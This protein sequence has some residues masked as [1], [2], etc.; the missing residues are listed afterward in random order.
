MELQRAGAHPR[1]LPARVCYTLDTSPANGRTN[2]QKLSATPKLVTILP[3][4]QMHTKTCIFHKQKHLII[5]GLETQNLST[6]SPCICDQPQQ[7]LFCLSRVALLN[8][9]KDSDYLFT[10]PFAQESSRRPAATVI[11]YT[12]SFQRLCLLDKNSILWS[13]SCS[14]TDFI[15]TFPNKTVQ[16]DLSTLPVN[17]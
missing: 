15:T 14:L 3:S 11:T 8:L 5:G 9:M 13:Y 17:H 10:F 6:V 7:M 1:C 2:T 12:Y 16:P 4:R